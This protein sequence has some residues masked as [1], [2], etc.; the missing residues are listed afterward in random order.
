MSPASTVTM[1]ASYGAPGRVPVV[2]VAVHDL[3]LW[4]AGPV[5][6]GAGETADVRVD[7]DGDHVSGS[8]PFSPTGSSGQ[9]AVAPAAR[10]PQQNPLV[11]SFR[12]CRL[13]P[14]T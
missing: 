13:G 14:G 5:E 12:R 3:D 11:V 6:V 10:S 9:F 4:I 2:A 7:V 8:N 1:I